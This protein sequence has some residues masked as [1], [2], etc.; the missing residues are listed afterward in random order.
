MYGKN[1]KLSGQQIGLLRCAIKTLR[2]SY[3]AY[4][5]LLSYIDSRGIKFKFVIDPSITANGAYAA[6]VPGD[7]SIRFRSA[8]CITS[9]KLRE[10]LIHAVQYQNY[11]SSMTNKVRNYEYE[12]K[13][14]QDLACFFGGG[15]CPYFG[16]YK[17]EEAYRNTYTTWI[18]DCFDHNNF[19]QSDVATFNNFCSHW[20]GYSGSCNSSFVPQLLLNFF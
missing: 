18:R 9:E 8:S 20:N 16:S 10:E 11:G 7:N 15:C 19:S 5:D 6:F 17:I 12:A 2:N 3:P 14:F 4:K 13:V 1:S